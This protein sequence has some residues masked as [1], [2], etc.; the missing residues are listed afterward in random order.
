MY[1]FSSLLPSNFLPSFV[2]RQ[3]QRRATGEDGKC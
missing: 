3:R 2:I 1:V